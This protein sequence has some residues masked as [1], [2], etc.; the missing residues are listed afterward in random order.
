MIHNL[1]YQGAYKEVLAHSTAGYSAP[2]ELQSRI[3]KYRA[4]IALGEASAVVSELEDTESSAALAAVKALA[5]FKAGQIDDSLELVQELVESEGE[6]ANVQV[7]G[8][9]V[10]YLAGK[11]EDAL[12][13]LSQHENSLAA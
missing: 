12:L 6:D 10:L 7:L 13:L 4:Q 3:Y 2:A 8:G 1:F 11:A 5:L 9:I